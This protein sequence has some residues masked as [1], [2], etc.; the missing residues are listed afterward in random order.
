M[1][2]KKNFVIYTFLFV[3]PYFLCLTLIGTCYDA[4]VNHY[5]SWWRL[6]VCAFIGACLMLAVKAIAQRP[7]KIITQR[8][9][10]QILKVL[11]NF[12]NIDYSPRNL[13]INFGVDGVLTIIF[14]LGLR[15]SFF[16]YQLQGTMVGWIIFLLILS[17]TLACNLEYSAFQNTK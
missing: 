7:I 16:L 2:N 12:F 17:L 11:I 15:R 10:N 1:S 13:Y 8:T 5:H 4:L 14:A 3:I 9:T 6:L